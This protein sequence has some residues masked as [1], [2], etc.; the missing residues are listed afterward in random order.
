[1]LMKE[2]QSNTLNF[3]ICIRQNMVQWRKKC[4][5]NDVSFL[6]ISCSISLK[7][8]WDLDSLTFFELLLNSIT[9][10]CRFT[11]WVRVIM[12]STFITMT[13][14]GQILSTQFCRNQRLKP[15]SLIAI[16]VKLFFFVLFD[17]AF[18]KMQYFEFF[19]KSTLWD[20][21][22]SL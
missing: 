2:A 21:N 8:K 4:L 19:H 15:W 16:A 1:M 9:I 18:H 12:Y 5:V 13:F 14:C 20:K 17:K 22:I 7:Y 3:Q 11:L 10:T 6:K